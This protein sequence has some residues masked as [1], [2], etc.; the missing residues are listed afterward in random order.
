[1]RYVN[2]GGTLLVTGSVERD[3]HWQVTER[4]GALGA[5]AAAES[6]LLR[7]ADAAHW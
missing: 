7:T 6:L 3:A 1:M 2:E 4:F 5:P